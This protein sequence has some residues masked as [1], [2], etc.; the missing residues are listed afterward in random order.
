MATGRR[1]TCTPFPTPDELWERCFADDN[2]WRDRFGAVP[3]ETAGG[4][5]E[6]RYYQHNAINAVLEA[7]GEG[8]R[9]ASC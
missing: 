4:K 1:A 3:F 2:D 7:I 8:D 6:L 9:A 5:W